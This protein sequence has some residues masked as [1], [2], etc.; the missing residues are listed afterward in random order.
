[1]DVELSALEERV[2]LLIAQVHA[3]REAN[4][5]L[6]R[7]LGVAAERNRDLATRITRAGTRLDALIAK[8]PAG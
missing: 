3:L 4:A 7:E 2:E 8:V 1:M 5:A 6:A